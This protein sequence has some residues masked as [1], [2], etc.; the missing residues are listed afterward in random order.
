MCSWLINSIDHCLL[1]KNLLSK[2][3]FS[4]WHVWSSFISLAFFRE[5][6]K[7]EKQQQKTTTRCE[8]YQID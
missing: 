6:K 1:N 7:K 5:K 3:F 8:E 4:K 2:Q